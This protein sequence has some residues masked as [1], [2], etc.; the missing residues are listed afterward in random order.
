MDDLKSAALGYA[1]NGLYV[2]PL[3]PQGKEPLTPK[4][5]KDASNDIEQVEKWWAQWPDA[6]IG[7]VTGAINK[8][9][10]LDIDGVLPADFPDLPKT[11]TVKTHGGCHYYFGWPE[12]GKEIRNKGKVHGYD[13][14]IRGNGGYV[15]APPSIHPEGGRYEFID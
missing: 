12:K 14:D 15:V 13:I 9:W 1:Q 5:Y 4:G 7:L 10:V 2:F 11:P 3:R 6:N 8:F